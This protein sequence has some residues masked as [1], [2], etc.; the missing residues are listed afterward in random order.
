MFLTGWAHAA[1]LRV[2]VVRAADATPLL[3]DATTRLGAVLLAAGFDLVE[4]DARTDAEART[5]IESAGKGA[6]MFAAL[7]LQ[8]VASGVAINVR[9][10]N[11][12][13]QKTSVRQIT[14]APQ[15]TSR[16]IALQALDLLLASLLEVESRPASWGDEGGTVNRSDSRIVRKGGR[17]PSESKLSESK[18][19]GRAA[20]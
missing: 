18:N 13:T 14:I 1:G 3:H 16:E 10:A 12:V 19:V 4:V 5:P 2:A 11:S 9:T 20:G 15:A 6:R 8:S 17:A 7:A